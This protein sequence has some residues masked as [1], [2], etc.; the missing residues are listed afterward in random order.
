MSLCTLRV[1][2]RG[3][4]PRFRHRALVITILDRIGGPLVRVLVSTGKLP[5]W[6]LL[7]STGVR[8]DSLV[9]PRKPSSHPLL[10]LQTV[11]PKSLLH[12][13][14]FPFASSFLDSYLYP[15]A[16]RFAP[17]AAS[18]SF[19]VGPLGLPLLV[20]NSVPACSIGPV[21]APS[22]GLDPSFRVIG[23]VPFGCAFGS[24]VI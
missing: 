3:L 2:C 18:C 22:N 11:A 6:L 14:R 13:P 24:W 21:L 12:P 9:Y 15:W 16:S 17:F 10:T 5:A 20:R 23:F 8:G 4:C 7:I 1:G 19:R